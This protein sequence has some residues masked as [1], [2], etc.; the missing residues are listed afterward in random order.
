[1]LSGDRPETVAAIAHDARNDLGLPFLVTFEARRPVQ[2]DALPLKLT[3]SHTAM[4]PATTPPGSSGA[5]RRPVRDSARTSVRITDDS[6]SVWEPQETRG[7]A[8]ASC[9]AMLSRY[10]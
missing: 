4:S 2:V 9:I 8:D 5:S 10:P 1:V 3:Y 7:E 6:S